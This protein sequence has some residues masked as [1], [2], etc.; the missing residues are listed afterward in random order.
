MRIIKS[1]EIRKFRSIFNQKVELDNLTI[2]SGRNNT[3]KSNVLKAL[4][5][6]F[7]EKSG[8]NQD[9]DHDKDY[10]RAYTG[11]AGGKREIEITLHFYGQGC[12]ALKEDF[13]ISRKFATFD[14][15]GEYKYHSQDEGV[16]KN[17]DR[18]NGKVTRQF[19]Y[20][21]N[22]LE[23][24]YVPVIRDK[25]FIKELFTLF[26]KLL[27]GKN[28]EKFKKNL[29]GLSDVLSEK[30]SGIS[31]DFEGFLN[32]K[33]QATLSTSMNEI[34][35][36]IVIEVDSGIKIQKSRS[37]KGESSTGRNHP[38]FVELFSSGDGVLMSYVPHFLSHICKKINK[39]NFIWGFE[40]PENSLEFSRTEDLA[41]KFHND[42][43]A[44]NGSQILLTTHSPAFIQLKDKP[45]VNLY[46]VYIKPND[47]TQA[48]EIKTIEGIQKELFKC[49]HYSF[50]KEEL[51]FIEMS[52]KLEDYY[53]ELKNSEEEYKNKLEQITKPVVFS[54]GNNVVFLE[55]ARELFPIGC[56]YDIQD[57]GG[58]GDIK[59]TIE[60]FSKL[61]LQFKSIFIFDC[62]VIQEYNKSKEF[63]K[64]FLCV[65]RFE[66]NTNNTEVKKGIEN[67]FDEGIFEKGSDFYQLKQVIVG[68]EIVAEGY[69]LDKNKFFNYVRENHR[70]EEAFYNFKKVQEFIKAQIDE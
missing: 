67:M 58:A 59:N 39:K 44:S 62:D 36:A 40:E 26:E 1:V 47:S 33:T 6:F 37:K 13:S 60:A 34:L 12:S 4:N 64:D 52:K 69:E 45:N 14:E 19:T 29:S 10:N 5:L 22:K 24:I 18:G 32:L 50:L 31:S 20:F 65:Y 46:R 70:T 7:N 51:G 41:N 8:F 25:S 30:S 57:G 55:I 63:K 17:I 48:S 28:G 43:S 27:E 35:S 16:Q 61:K 66:E 2:F 23:Y 53:Q 15:V 42:F 54:E 68:G 3:G 56:D 11:A 49:P 21:L 38:I 9:Y